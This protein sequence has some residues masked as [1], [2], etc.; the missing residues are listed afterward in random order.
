MKWP[1]LKCPTCN[2]TLDNNKVRV[3]KP[4]VCPSCSAELQPSERQAYIGELAA[5]AIAICISYLFGLRGLWLLG[6]SVVMWFPIA[7]AW[8]FVF[9]RIVPPKFESYRPLPT[10]P[11]LPTPPWKE[12]KFVTLFPREHVDS[13]QSKQ[14][15]HSN[16]DM[17]RGS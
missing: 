15:D 5:I 2:A 6:A 17:P 13:D 8:V 14:S 7:M 9:V 3:G 16:D 12:P 4:L 1:V 10:L 11:Q